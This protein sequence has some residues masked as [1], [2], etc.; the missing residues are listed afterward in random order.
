MREKNLFEFNIGKQIE[1]RKISSLAPCVQRD[2][3]PIRSNNG[4]HFFYFFITPHN[5]SKPESRTC[6]VH[7]R[8]L[9]HSF[10]TRHLISIVGEF[11]FQELMVQGVRKFFFHLFFTRYFHKN[12]CARSVGIFKTC[13]G[14]E[15]V[16]CL[17]VYVEWRTT[18]TALKRLKN[19]NAIGPLAFTL[20]MVDV[21]QFKFH[22]LN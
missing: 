11:K 20:M 9:S 10:G 17:G 22:I 1:F 3:I 4:K 6:L 15:G 16:T 2:Q 12:L 7:Q 14:D 18:T 13:W 21:P 8:F 5:T 19:R